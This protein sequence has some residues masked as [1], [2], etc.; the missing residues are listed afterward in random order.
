MKYKNLTIIGTSHIAIESVKNVQKQIEKIEP[1]TVAIELDKERF[2]TLLHKDKKPKFS[3]AMV[4]QFGF[5]GFIFTLIGAWVEKKLGKLV[6]VSPGTEMMVAVKAAAKVNANVALVDRDLRVTVRHL[7]KYL[8]WKEKF[9]F[10]WDIFAG[11]VLRKKVI[12]IDLR[13]VPSSQLISRMIEEVR[14][15]YPSFYKALVK[16]RDEYMAKNLYSLMNKEKDKEI[17]AVVGA[18]HEK[19]IISL[20]KKY[21]KKNLKWNTQNVKS[22]T[23]HS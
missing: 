2:I 4:R 13:K 9:R 8:T 16:E 5:S 22:R 10:L 6:G 18:G 14:E 17:V 11:L 3:W 23:L 1:A 19:N 15:R 20:L 7:F 12:K 21:F